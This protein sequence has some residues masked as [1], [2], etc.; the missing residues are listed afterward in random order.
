MAPA[1]EESNRYSHFDAGDSRVA[2][3]SW[4][5]VAVSALLLIF[6]LALAASWQTL[7]HASCAKCGLSLPEARSRSGLGD[8]AKAAG[9]GVVLPLKRI[10]LQYSQLT[11][12]PPKHCFHLFV[13][14][15]CRAHLQ[16]IVDHD[17]LGVTVATNHRLCAIAQRGILEKI[18]SIQ[19]QISADMSP[20]HAG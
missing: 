7:G 4:M 17:A 9:G 19:A 14:Q 3:T 11:A 15:T 12:T 8:S 5:I 6:L 18:A 13:C 20:A 16:R 2:N 10:G 1:T